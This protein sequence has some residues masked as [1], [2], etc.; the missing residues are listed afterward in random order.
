MIAPALGPYAR[1]R[2][3]T[4]NPSQVDQARGQV[5]PRGCY[6]GIPYERYLWRVHVTRRGP[7]VE[8]LRG[9]KLRDGR[10]CDGM[11]Y[12]VFRRVDHRLAPLRRY[13]A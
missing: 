1:N 10:Y 5:L 9:M 13:P 8:C 6:L 2:A 7:G 4:V 12:W 3:S 11:G